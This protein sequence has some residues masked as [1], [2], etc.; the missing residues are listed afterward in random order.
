MLWIMTASVL[1]KLSLQVIRLT[2]TIVGVAKGIVSMIYLKVS[3]HQRIADRH[4]FKSNNQW[5]KSDCICVKDSHHLPRIVG[6]S[7][8]VIDRLR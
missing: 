8:C 4:R 7:Y 6:R 5:N 3:H 1:V 2:T